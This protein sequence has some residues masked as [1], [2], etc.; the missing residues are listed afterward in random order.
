VPRVAFGQCGKT[1]QVEAPWTQHD[2]GLVAQ[3]LSDPFIA[4]SYEHDPRF[5]ALCKEAGLSLP[6]KA[7]PAEA[8]M[9]T[10]ATWQ[11]G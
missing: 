2:P 5:A 10:T 7:L 3:L 1:G 6:V 8:G 4:R 11:G 9:A